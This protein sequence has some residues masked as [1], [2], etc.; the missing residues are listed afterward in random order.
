MVCSDRTPP[1]VR[2][3]TRNCRYNAIVHTIRDGI[4]G[5]FGFVALAPPS[6]SSFETR[7][8]GAH[9]GEGF[10]AAAGF[11]DCPMKF[12]AKPKKASC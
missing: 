8:A 10:G 5:A 2:L 7:L 9:Q 6:P 1:L 12:S 11:Q 3:V 4:I